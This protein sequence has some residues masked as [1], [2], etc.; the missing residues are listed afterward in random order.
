M[1][2]ENDVAMRA[3]LSS[4]LHEACAREDCPE[5]IREALADWFTTG[6]MAFQKPVRNHSDP[7]RYEWYRFGCAVTWVISDIKGMETGYRY[8]EAAHHGLQNLRS[9][10]NELG[11]PDS[12]FLVWHATRCPP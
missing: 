9:R 3:V 8:R 11:K 4:L 12:K 6:E 2:P 10:L 5:D 1:I 7:V